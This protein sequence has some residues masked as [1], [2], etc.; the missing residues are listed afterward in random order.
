MEENLAIFV[1]RKK[2]ATTRAE[3]EKFTRD[4]SEWL[5]DAIPF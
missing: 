1:H 5:L 4:V 3:L 2:K